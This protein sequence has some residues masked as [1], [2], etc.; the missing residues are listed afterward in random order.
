MSEAKLSPTLQTALDAIHHAT[1]GMTAEQ[2][3]WHPEGKWSSAQILEHLALA[4][5]RT[6]E[7]MKP[8]LQQESPEVRNRT[9]REWVGGLI[10]LKLG[11]IPPGRKAPEAVSPR[12][13]APDQT[14]A[15]ARSNLAELDTTIDRCQQRFGSAKNILVHAI[16]GPLSTGEWR[17]FHSVHTLHHMRQIEGLRE[18][19][20]AAT[21]KP[22]AIKAAV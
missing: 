21:S 18:R 12:G 15:F 13:M 6:A 20:N 4:Y 1:N 5:S 8:L 11:R 22:A 7:R 17:R 9:F 2:L 3:A 14:V 10:V 19:M 16:L